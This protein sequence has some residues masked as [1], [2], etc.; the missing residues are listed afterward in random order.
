MHKA[1]RDDMDRQVTLFRTELGWLG[2]L[3][4]G[5]TVE[6]LQMGHAT[7]DEVRERLWYEYPDGWTESD[8]WPELQIG[9]AH[10]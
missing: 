8:W 2:L 7:A 3:G 10:V 1:N 9:R 4:C 6:R 5:R